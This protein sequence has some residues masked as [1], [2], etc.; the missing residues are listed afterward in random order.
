MTLTKLLGNNYKWWYVVWFSIIRENTGFR[1]FLIYQLSHI[2]RILSTLYIW[3]LANS[4]T[5]TFS[6]LL[7]GQIYRSVVDNIFY[8]RLSDLIYSGAISS[9]LLQPK[10]FLL[11]QF[12]KSI[13]ARLMKNF[14]FVIGSSVAMIIAANT[15]VRISFGF[16]N[17]NLLIAMIPISFVLNFIFGALVGSL[18]FWIK[19]RRDYEGYRSSYEAIIFVITGSTIPL[20]KFPIEIYR[21]LEILPTAWIIHHPMQIYLGKYDSNQIIL[22]FLG[23]LAWCVVLYIL[24]KI[25]FKLGLKRNESVGL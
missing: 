12:V 14:Y 22:V 1:G 7:L 24:A 23:G 10:P 16:T 3:Y 5:L 17:V 19:D 2:V 6:Y 9:D 15:F 21:V 20:Y 8:F 4:D 13:G 25:M 18:A 11:T